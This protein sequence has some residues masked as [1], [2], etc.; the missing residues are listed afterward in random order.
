M[1]DYTDKPHAD[2]T[3]DRFREAG[4]APSDQVCDAFAVVAGWTG[5][6]Y[7]RARAV[8]AILLHLTLEES[9]MEEA[10]NEFRELL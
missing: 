9:T 10:M 7:Y 5:T 1:T 4:R 8:A 3:Q 6:E 2:Q